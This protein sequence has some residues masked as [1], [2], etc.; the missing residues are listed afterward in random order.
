MIKKM[1]V[2]VAVCGFILAL[3][4]A[5]ANDVEAETRQILMTDAE[6][7]MRV[8]VS[9]LMLVGGTIG[10]KICNHMEKL[11]RR[12]K[13]L[14]RAYRAYDNQQKYTALKAETKGI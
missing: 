5:G 7:Y 9:G 8:L 3:G 10:A 1:F 2:A 14:Q 13:A 6:F 4:T 12:H 11:K